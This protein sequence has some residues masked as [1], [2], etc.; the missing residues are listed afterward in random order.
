M[1][2]PIQGSMIGRRCSGRVGGRDRGVVDEFNALQQLDDLGQRRFVEVLKISHV[3]H[4]SAKREIA[5]GDAEGEYAGSPFF[6]AID[7]VLR[8]TTGISDLP[9]QCMECCM[10]FF[11]AYAFG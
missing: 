10:C 4:Y 9:M 8:N 2:S 7:V 1:R 3:P 11:G 5:A 6:V